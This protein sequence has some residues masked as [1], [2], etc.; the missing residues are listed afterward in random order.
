MRRPVIPLSSTRPVAL[1]IDGKT[2][3]RGFRQAIRDAIHG[4]HLLEEMQLRYDWPNGTIET[5]D[6]EAHRQA[7]HSQIARRT[8]YV[9]LCHEL[10]PTGKVVSKYGQGLPDYCPL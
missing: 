6:W 7:T 9:K 8:H 4:P 3:H 2:I 5:I 1:D 10:L